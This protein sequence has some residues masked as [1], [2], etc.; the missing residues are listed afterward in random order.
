MMNSNMWTLVVI[1][2]NQ[3]YVGMRTGRMC[4]LCAAIVMGGLS[5]ILHVLHI[6]E[7]CMC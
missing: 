4:S 2:H 5:N 3:A 7:A 6:L 1:F